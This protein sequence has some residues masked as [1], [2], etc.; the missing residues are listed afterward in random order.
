MKTAVLLLL[1]LA[2]ISCAQDK[3]MDNKSTENKAPETTQDKKRLESVTWDLKTHKLVWVV[4]HGAEEN[5]EFVAKSSDRY[6][7]SPDDAVMAFSDEKRGFTR[8]EA[9]SLHKL[10]DTL[11]LYCAES[12]IWWDQGEGNPLDGAPGKKPAEGNGQRVE[13]KPHKQVQ[14]EDHGLLVAFKPKD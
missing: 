2:G 10:L 14:P 12:V 9:S 6:E 1:S 4:E 3:K 5:G 8:E 11:S 13:Q 7:I